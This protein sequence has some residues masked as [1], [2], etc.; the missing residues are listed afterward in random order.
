MSKLI[1][2]LKGERYLIIHDVTLFN[3]CTCSSH[4]IEIRHYRE[5]HR[6]NFGLSNSMYCN[7]WTVLRENDNYS[8]TLLETWS[9]DVHLC[10]VNESIRHSVM[11][12]FLEGKMWLGWY[13]NP[14]QRL[15]KRNDGFHLLFS[16]L[17]WVWLSSQS[18]CSLQELLLHMASKCLYL[19]HF[20]GNFVKKLL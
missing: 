11:R 15:N 10:D 18:H 1:L 19:L 20:W 4:Y 13:P 6:S 8:S 9:Y 3:T 5:S 7:S 2:L 12:Q 17:L 16:V 14:K